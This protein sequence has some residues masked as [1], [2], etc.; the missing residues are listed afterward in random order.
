MDRLLANLVIWYG[1]HRRG[2]NTRR[3]PSNFG[4]DFTEITFPSAGP[5]EAELYGWLIPAQQPKGLV[6]LCHGIDSGAHAMLPKAAMLSRN[7]YSTLLFDFR[8]TGRSGGDC[9]TL[10]LHEASDVLGAVSFAGSQPAL[11]H[12]PILAIGESMGGSAVIRAAATCDRIRAI[13]SES[14]YATLSD[15]LHRRL[16]LLGPFAQRVAEHCRRI[17]EDKF[18]IQ[19]FV[20]L[21]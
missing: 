12:L 14:T 1:T 5:R 11:N 20:L 17:G 7:G 9:V 16:K 21:K 2:G 4:L 13:V 10:G 8:A 6:L 18:D 15:A 3:N 19:I